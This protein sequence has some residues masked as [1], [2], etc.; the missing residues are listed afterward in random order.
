MTR[1]ALLVR[2][3]G[4]FT[5]VQDRGRFGHQRLGVPT[6]GA[7]D[8]ASY[9]LANALAGAPAGAAALEM[10]LVGPTLEA[11]GG[12]V[13]LAV[14]GAEA[15]LEIAGTG[16]SGPRRVK[17]GESVTV[18]AGERVAVGPLASSA[19]AYLAVAGG[20]DV[21]L[22]MGSAST[23]VRGRFGGHEGRALAVGDRL[24]LCQDGPPAGL[25]RRLPP[26]PI[27]PADYIRVV[28]GPQ[29]DHFTDR[30]FATLLE[31]EWTVSSEADRM[32]LRLDGPPI[33]HAGGYN[34]ASD[35]IATGAIQVPGSG[36]PIVLLADRQTTG[37]YPKIATVIS[38]DLPHLGRMAPGARFRFA[39]V[40]PDEASAAARAH[41]AE[42]CRLERAITTF[43]SGP[44][45]TAALLAA[46]L[47]SGVWGPAA[48]PRR[49]GDEPVG[50]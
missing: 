21:P 19:T 12:P 44:P 33:E 1:A 35:G 43:T 37:G 15:S 17:S 22:I 28:P 29:R 8:A 10:R 45:D 47:I 27:Q 2:Q 48:A 39:A 31:A 25:E 16:G 30:G 6:S 34:I 24:S 13:R 11:V 46:N 49:D 42:L 32:G 3:P 9:R 50:D 36:Q 4:F 41:E 20:L 40:A 14:V 23:Y 26:W 7:L 5:T 38:A 18:R